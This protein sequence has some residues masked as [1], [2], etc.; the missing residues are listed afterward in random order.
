[1]I[2]QVEEVS[3]FQP[4][5]ACTEYPQPREIEVSGLDY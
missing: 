3:I 5:V 4:F 1:M 2:E